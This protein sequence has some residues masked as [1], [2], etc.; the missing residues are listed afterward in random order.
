[1]T[2]QEVDK[3][4]KERDEAKQW[5]DWVHV[6]RC[7]DAVQKHFPALLV[8][9]RAAEEV[10]QLTYLIDKHMDDCNIGNGNCDCGRDE[11]NKAVSGLSAA[12]A[13]LREIKE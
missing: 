6:G 5:D 13:R 11:S 2:P 7:E 12:L 3:I 4:L 9:W 1:M 8:L 10:D